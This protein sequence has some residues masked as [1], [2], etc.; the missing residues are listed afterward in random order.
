DA[1]APRAQRLCL[2]DALPISREARLN[3][4][5][6]VDE[7]GRYSSPI[8]SVGA[9]FFTM[10]GTLIRGRVSVGAASGAS[11]RTALALATRYSLVRRDRKS[12]RLNSSHVST[13][14]AV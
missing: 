4:V 11:A 13:S 9:R 1:D 3:R 14:Y 8:E 6:A 10:L 12:T 7:Q 2:H 5:G